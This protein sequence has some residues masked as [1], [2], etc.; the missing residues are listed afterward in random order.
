M[1]S[2]HLHKV[3]SGAYLR[4]V[5]NLIPKLYKT[6]PKDRDGLLVSSDRW[7]IKYSINDIDT[8]SDRI[9]YE[10]LEEFSYEAWQQDVFNNNAFEDE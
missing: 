3:F 1:S 9:E 2:P 6:M 10:S 4:G 5:G 8:S 7:N